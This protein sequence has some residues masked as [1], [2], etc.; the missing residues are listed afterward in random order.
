MGTAAAAA[1]RSTAFCFR[2]QAWYCY[3]CCEYAH[4]YY[5]IYGTY[6]P[7]GPYGDYTFDCYTSGHY[8]SGHY[9]SG[10]YA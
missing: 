3:A 7:Y 6:G 2:V 9:T 5:Y 4:V 10:Y 1:C 8:T